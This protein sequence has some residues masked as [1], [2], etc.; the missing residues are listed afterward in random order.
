MKPLAVISNTSQKWLLCTL[1]SLLGL[2]FLFLYL[3]QPQNPPTILSPFQI[4]DPFSENLVP[5]SQPTE[6]QEMGVKMAPLP[7]IMQKGEFLPPPEEKCD[8]FDGRWVYDPKSY[9]LYQ[10]RQCPFLSDQVTCRKNGRPD[11]D[12]EHWRWEARGCEI[13]RFNGTDM[14]ERLRGKRV[15]IIGD[16]LNRNQWESLI[17]LLYS[18]IRPSRAIVKIRRSVRIFRAKDYDCSVEFFWSP[19]L[20]R[21]DEMKDGSKTVKLEKLTDSARQWQ[22]ADVMI[23]NTGYW[24]THHGKQKPWKYF[25]YRGE[26]LEKMKVDTAFKIA[27][28]TWAR[29][30]DQRVDP[31]KT[32]VF[33]RS[34]SPVHKKINLQWCFNQVHPITNETYVQWF[35]R[36]MVSIIESTISEM[37][38]PVKYLNIT[39][40]SEYRQDAHT[41]IYTTRKSKFLT[42]EQRSQPDEYADCDH[43]CLPGVPDTW[44]ALLYAFIVL[45]I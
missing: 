24:W 10:W 6:F 35:P 34:I 14:L 1:A 7:S 36:P 12:Y 33:F 17:C 32:S 21:M 26:L 29:W 41:S 28:T 5:T 19:F 40:L 2:I 23:F 8:V 3:K 20:V 42:N 15:V 16:S 30:I 18:S 39:R 22:G 27:M 4:S 44:N 13:P 25:E 43:W 31:A 9:P 38:T 37:R 45:K 11:S